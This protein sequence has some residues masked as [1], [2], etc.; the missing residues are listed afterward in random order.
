MRY[1]NSCML[2]KVYMY[3]IK[4]YVIY[5]SNY[6]NL[7]LCIVWIWFIYVFRIVV[8]SL[9]LCLKEKSIGGRNF[10]LLQMFILKVY[11]KNLRIYF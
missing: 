9:F 3:C 1:F 2:L 11:N 10:C 8:Y 6:E 4:I 7:M 5:Q